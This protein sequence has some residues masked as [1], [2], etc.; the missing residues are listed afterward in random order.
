MM[1]PVRK[2]IRAGDIEH[3][4]ADIA[5]AATFGFRPEYTLEQGLKETLAALSEEK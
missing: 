3:S 1:E 5:R 4:Q 2:D